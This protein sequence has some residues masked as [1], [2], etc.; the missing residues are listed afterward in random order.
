MDERAL[1]CPE[2]QPLIGWRLFR[3]RPSSAGVVL[4]APL[5]HNPDFE[6][7]PSRT[8]EAICY[9][10]EH[11][12]P[13]PGCRCGLYAALDGTL[14]SLSGYLLDSAH[15]GDP[16][17][18]AE[19][20]CTGR[21]FVDARGVRAQRIEVLR[22]AT[23]VSLWPDPAVHQRATAEL[24]ERYGVEVCDLEA[25]PGWLQTN[26][27]PH[28]APPEDAAV[29]LDALLARVG[30]KPDPWPVA[31]AITGRPRSTFRRTAT[32]RPA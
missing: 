27:M 8:I 12:A 14:D 17:I 10:R 6:R 5:I 13:A 26:A 9:E 4:S 32:W 22:L 24:G 30:I 21:V 7:F 28:G 15:D 23:S 29:D 2:D 19:V 11:P 25:V 31:S 18:F 20:A 1:H 3:V 16:P